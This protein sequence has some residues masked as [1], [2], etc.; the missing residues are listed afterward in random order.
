M[1]EFPK[2]GS[3]IADNAIKQAI[4][5]RDYPTAPIQAGRAGWMAARQ[6]MESLKIPVSTNVLKIDLDNLSESF[7]IFESKEE[8]DAHEYSTAGYHRFHNTPWGKPH[9]YPGPCH[10]FWNEPKEFPCI[11]IEVATVDNPNGPYDVYSLIIE[12]EAFKKAR[13]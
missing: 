1:T 12:G 2:E 7:H 4:K 3:E 9:P 10:R 13:S 8:Y 6:Y 11:M 5:E